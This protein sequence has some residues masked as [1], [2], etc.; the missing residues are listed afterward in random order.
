MK[1]IKSDKIMLIA[2]RKII[3]GPLNRISKRLSVGDEI[4]NS[5]HCVLPQVNERN[6]KSLTKYVDIPRQN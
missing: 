6:Q 5:I 3:A 2:Y 4:S 1:G